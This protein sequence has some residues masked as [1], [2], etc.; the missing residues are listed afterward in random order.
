MPSL[1]YTDE[2]NAQQWSLELSHLEDLQVTLGIALN[3]DTVRFTTH[4]VALSASERVRVRVTE[5][6]VLLFDGFV[7]ERIRTYDPD[8]IL[9]TAT[10]VNPTTEQ[11]LLRQLREGTLRGWNFRGIEPYSATIQAIPDKT[12]RGLNDEIAERMVEPDLTFADVVDILYTEYGILM[13]GILLYPIWDFRNEVA[14]A[15][16]DVLPGRRFTIPNQ[17]NQPGNVANLDFRSPYLRTTLNAPLLS[18]SEGDRN[19]DPTAYKWL[20]K[21]NRI[22]KNEEGSLYQIAVDKWILARESAEINL[23]TPLRFDLTARSKV[24]FPNGFWEYD[25]AWIVDRVT[26]DWKAYTTQIV[27]KVLEG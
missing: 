4:E 24:T 26:Y 25:T 14:L 12:F 20:V 27:G 10:A 5:Q 18:G 19:I 6:D 7:T 2:V 15:A 9:I 1:T 3:V 8:V 23:T 21:D 11:Y 16:G 13:H 17:A 22:Q